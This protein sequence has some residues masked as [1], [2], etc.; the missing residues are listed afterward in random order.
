MEK[1]NNYMNPYLAGILLGL[2]LLA[3]FYLS[4]RGLGASGA[5]KSVVVATVDKV[6]PSHT[7][8]SSFYSK[9]T[10]EGKHP[11]ISWLVFLALGVI[12]GA[13]F[14]GIASGRAGFSIEKGPRIKNRTRLMMAVLGGIL[15]GVGAQF[16]RGC[17]SGAALSGMAVL[18]TAGFL[19]MISIFG[20]GYL[21]AWALKKFW[22]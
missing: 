15:F 7:E 1:K 22:V 2:V 11:M 10:G 19:S 16:G 5:M 18:S 13:N 4:G 12:I 20:T 8:A 9:Y 6:A 14:S 21:V 3:A 17:T